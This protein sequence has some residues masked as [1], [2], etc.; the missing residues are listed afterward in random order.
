MSRLAELPQANIVKEKLWIYV[1]QHSQKK[2]LTNYICC[3]KNTLRQLVTEG[4]K[5]LS[6]LTPELE[7]NVGGTINAI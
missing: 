3:A 5:D 6:T 1:Q 7:K 2:S 4:L